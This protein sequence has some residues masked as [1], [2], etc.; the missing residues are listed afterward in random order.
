[1]IEYDD[2]TSAT[3]GSLADLLRH[4]RTQVGR[5][6]YGTI[7]LCERAMRLR[8]PLNRFLFML[9][10][11]NDPF[12]SIAET[13]WVL[14]G[15]DDIEWL[16]SYLPRA[17]DFSDDGTTWRAAYGPRLR[18]WRGTDPL[19]NVVRLLRDEPSTR[20]ATLSLFDPSLDYADTLDVPCTIAIQFM[21]RDD[22][23]NAT[24]TMRSNDVWWGFSGINAFEW[25]V[26]LEAVALWTGTQVG[27]LTF[28]AGSFHLYEQHREKAVAALG[29]YEGV[30]PYEIASIGR[31]CFET[32]FDRFDETLE[33][34]FAAEAGIT[35]NPDRKPTSTGDGL[36]DNFLAVL[37]VKRAFEAG[38]TSSELAEM[39][40]GMLATDVAAA[41][42][43]WIV[44]I[45]PDVIDAMRPGPI[46]S[47]VKEYRTVTSGHGETTD[48]LQEA[49]SRLHRRKDKAYGAAWKKR[50]E[51]RSILPNVAR[52]IDRLENYARRGDD[53]GDESLLDTAVD[54]LVYVVK[55]ML[56]LRDD[57]KRA[58]SEGLLLQDDPNAFDDALGK[59]LSEAEPVSDLARTIEAAVTSFAAVDKH[60][61]DGGPTEER[62]KLVH[63][64]AK[65]T[66]VLV[67][68]ISKEHKLQ[69]TLL[70]ANERRMSR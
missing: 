49:I 30:T 55:H 64:L 36:L 62:L 16:S 5:K 67:L 45:K 4:G 19:T 38:A 12:A 2:V 33:R 69:T 28:F 24:V 52:K 3:A 6:G 65:N 66:A 32:P 60:E 25:S 14:A 61:R 46:R 31:S 17:R 43:E 51:A 22:R 39:V 21:I 44:R 23:L 68:S 57:L 7:E 20:R 9:G 40:D 47:F 11:G 10:R 37:R 56:Y 18:N 54:T 8:N 59:F 58:G 34:F 15:R 29:R 70:I 63:V 48:A 53:M 26:L 1:M 27:T 41:T 13:I 42:T 35:A 50:G